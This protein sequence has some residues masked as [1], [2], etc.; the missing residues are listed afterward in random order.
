MIQVLWIEERNSSK[1]MATSRRML[2][3]E[4]RECHSAGTVPI[5]LTTECGRENL[6]SLL[7]RRISNFLL[8]NKYIDFS[9]QNSGIPTTPRTWMFGAYQHDFTAAARSERR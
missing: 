2:C 3:S 1:G 4:R 7:V 6:L 5:N 8:S 9:V